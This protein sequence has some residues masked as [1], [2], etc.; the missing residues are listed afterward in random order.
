MT[1]AVESRPMTVSISGANDVDIRLAPG[2]SV[3][4]ALL[5]ASQLLGIDMNPEK[6]DVVV[7]AQD[8]DLDDVV[9]EDAE[10]I[11]AAAPLVNG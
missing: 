4:D 8:A 2:A 5:E 7:D 6:Y 1:A 10:V 9:A 11:E 3:R